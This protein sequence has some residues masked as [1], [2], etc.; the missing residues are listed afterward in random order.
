MPR[1]FRKISKANLQKYIQFELL[2]VILF[3]QNKILVM[4]IYKILL[5]SMISKDTS[6]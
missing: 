6:R 4:A 5:L 1:G 2:S 3:R